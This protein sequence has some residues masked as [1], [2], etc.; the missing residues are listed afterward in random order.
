[1][2]TKDSS[3]HG[4][5]VIARDEYAR[6]YAHEYAGTGTPLHP[7]RPGYWVMVNENGA[8]VLYTGVTMKDER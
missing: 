7:D 5:Q 1:M 3:E 6:M 8:T 2:L 4:W